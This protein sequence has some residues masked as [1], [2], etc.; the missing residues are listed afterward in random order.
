MA[1]ACRV[2]QAPG[3]IS[4]RTALAA[5]LATMGGYVLICGIS[6]FD[7]AGANFDPSRLLITPFAAY[8][9]RPF[10]AA[11]GS[12]LE[13]AATYALLAALVRSYLFVGTPL[14]GR[15]SA[16]VT[17]VAVVSIALAC[18]VLQVFSASRHADLTDVLPALFASMIVAHWPGDQA[19]A[20]A[21]SSSDKSLRSADTSPVAIPTAVGIDQPVASR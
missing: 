11:M 1:V 14:R 3:A 10:G 18:E 17:I 5:I 19:L 15:W 7:L 13:M 2:W 4:I 8:V 16:T 12:I 6:P 21:W 20:W 9:A